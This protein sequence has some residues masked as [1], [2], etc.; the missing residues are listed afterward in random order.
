MESKL[1][2]MHGQCGH[3][4][5]RLLFAGDDNISFPYYKVMPSTPHAHHS[6]FLADSIYRCRLN[7][8]P[9]IQEM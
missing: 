4:L 9:D 2:L 1:N 6:F 5:S 3:R 7:S 8:A